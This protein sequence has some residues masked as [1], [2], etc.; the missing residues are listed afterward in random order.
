MTAVLSERSI[1][2]NHN[3]IWGNTQYTIP[4]IQITP[5]K[6]RAPRLCIKMESK[7]IQQF[8]LKVEIVV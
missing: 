6:V 2:L 8:K 3:Q 5:G 7:I 1:L 4:G